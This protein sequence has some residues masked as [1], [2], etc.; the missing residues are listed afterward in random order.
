MAT[1]IKDLTGTV[2]GS[3]RVFTTPTAFESGTFRPIWN[4]SVYNQD[5]DTFGCVE[6]SSTQ[7]TLTTAPLT[8]TI[9]Q[10]FYVEEVAVGS[11]FDPDGVLP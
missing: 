9:M 8:G 11:P 7:V 3:N 1:V 5:D 10:G 2:N 4:G 6:D